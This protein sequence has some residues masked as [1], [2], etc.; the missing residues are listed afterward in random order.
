MKKFSNYI[1]F[2]IPIIIFA[3]AKQVSLTGGDKDI[4]PPELT[5]SK[6]ETGTVNFAENVITFKFNEYVK[7]NSAQQK[8]IVSPPL[9][10][11]P[12]VR[13]NG[14][15]VKILFD[16][17]KLKDNTTYSINLSNIIGDNNENNLI[18]SFI[19]SFSTGNVIDSL[20][21]SG[22]L[23]DV[24]TGEAMEDVTVLLHS[25]MSDSAFSKVIP[26]YIAKTD[27]Y[28]AFL[29]PNLS[30][31]KYKIFALKDINN[32]YIFDLPT[33]EI[34]FIDSIIIPSVSQIS[35]MEYDTVAKDTVKIISSIF[36]PDNIELF[37]F[38]ENKQAQFIKTKDRL[39]ENHLQIIFNATQYENFE[40]SFKN[41]PDSSLIIQN[42][43]NPDTISIWIKDS[44][45][46][47]KDS[48]TAFIKYKDPI[49]LDS[50]HYDTVIFN[51]ILNK[52]TDSIEN[53]IIKQD[54]KD[55]NKFILT[56][57]YPILDFYQ[58]KI[59]LCSD[60]STKKLFPIS[61]KKDSIDPRKIIITTTNIEE[62]SNLLFVIDSA[63]VVD[64]NGLVNNTS[65]T[66][67]TTLSSKSFGELTVRLK[68]NKKYIVELLQ[69]DKLKYK[70]ISE[71]NLISFDKIKPGK[72]KIKIT[73]DLNG[74]GRW[75]TGDYSK[76]LQAE[77]IFFYPDQYEIKE[78]FSHEV[79]F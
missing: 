57:K 50:I 3:C 69:S 37:L 30:E 22:K 41:I 39:L 73:E 67:I 34:A 2:L 7:L 43:T 79:I 9:E 59:S 58:E 27:K 12:T 5:L 32:N 21:I 47:K 26:D 20:C 66:K 13:L 62:N 77:P 75:D 54:I 29:L 78:N 18:S 61:L 25:D 24:L 6:P 65:K 53:I 60:D 63:F 64:I 11:N 42:I 1:I 71:S 68:E 14:K 49:Y 46:S 8:L 70:K 35:R 74:N 52:F 15:Y 72:Y 23:S 76:K 45:F 17:T 10:T 31:K 56:T 51:N 44:V 36:K 16:D 28:G 55:F 38:R 33:E 19:Y 48:I 4:T 40:I